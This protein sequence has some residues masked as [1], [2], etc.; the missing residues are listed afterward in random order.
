MPK[1]IGAQNFCN[2]S[3]P[4]LQTEATI[5]F[6]T[7]HF[8]SPIFSLYFNCHKLFFTDT[9]SWMHPLG[10]R[11]VRSTLLLCSQPIAT[12]E[13]TACSMGS[14]AKVVTFGGSN[15][16][17]CRFVWKA[18]HL[19]TFQHVSWHVKNRVWQARYFCE[20]FNKW[21]PFLEAGTSV[22]SCCV[23]F[24]NR[25]VR[26]VSSGDNV[27]VAWH[28]WHFVTYVMKNWRKP[29]TKHQLEVADLGV[30]WFMRKIRRKMS[31]LYL[32]SVNICKVSYEMVVLSF[33]HA[34]SRFSSFIV[35]VVSRGFRRVVLRVFCKSHCQS[36]VKRWL[37]C[38]WPVRCGGSWGCHFAWQVQYLVM[39]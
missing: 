12:V 8:T 4:T 13:V 20:V 17:Q 25:M 37:R 14:A 26:A 35:A 22:V 10:L 33:L 29:R 5:F 31:I 3:Y 27:Q 1:N 24:A 11:R 23:F 32:Q 39:F 9:F 16:A 15:V 2:S 18:W 36:C 21:I 19:V 30:H 7:L 38:K 28:A 34:S 6:R